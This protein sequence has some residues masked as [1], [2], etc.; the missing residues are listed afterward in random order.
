MWAHYANGLRGFCIGFDEED[1]VQEARDSYLVD[2]EYLS[3]P[4]TVD[5]FLYAVAEDQ[6]DYHMMVIDEHERR[7]AYFGP[8]PIPYEAYQQCADEALTTMR[9]IWRR[10]FASKPA[11]WQYERESRLLLSVPGNDRMPVFHRY[12]PSAVVE[13]ILGER[14]EEGYRAQ[15]LRIAQERYPHAVVRS[16]HRSREEFKL[17]TMP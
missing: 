13:L 5:G 6:Y 10:A 9:R 7:E 2:V 8:E 12:S 11:E 3:E 1:F 16:A 4:P 15:L 17:V 14:M